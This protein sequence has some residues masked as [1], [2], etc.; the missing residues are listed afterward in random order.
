MAVFQILFVLIRQ[1]VG[2]LLNNTNEKKNRFLDANFFLPCATGD[3]VCSK[4]QYIFSFSAIEKFYTRTQ[5]NQVDLQKQHDL[6]I[7]SKPPV[8]LYTPENIDAHAI[9]VDDLDPEQRDEIY[10]SLDLGEIFTSSIDGLGLLYNFNENIL[11]F[12]M[13]DVDNRIVGF[14]A[15]SR[16][17][18]RIIE[19]TVPDTRSWGMVMV[20][21]VSKRGQKES[22]AAI[23]VLNVLDV[24]A[25]RTQNISCK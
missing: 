4:C 21:P 18:K 12:P 9:P 15:L 20:P 22:K 5:K 25:L 10:T 7:K 11:Y 23:L 14:K 16:R 24:L 19:E 6:F 17:N 8:Q 2:L 3:V 13:H 1:Q